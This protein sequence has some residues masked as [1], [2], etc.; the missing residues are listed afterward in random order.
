MFLRSGELGR[1]EQGLVREWMLC[2]EEYPT[3]ELDDVHTVRTEL[4]HEIVCSHLG[5]EGIATG[6]DI[7]R[8]VA[9]LRPGVNREMRL[10]DHDHT[11]DPERIELVEDHV[12]DR[13]L[14]ALCGLDHRRLHDL[15]ATDRFPIAVEEL[16][17]Q[18]PTE[19]VH[20]LTSIQ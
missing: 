17:Q 12:H 10:G 5:L 8:G 11:G 1:N 9:I 15:E 7:H 19:C 18:V 16:H 13:R 2:V 4:L 14:G 20:L 3:L 6:E